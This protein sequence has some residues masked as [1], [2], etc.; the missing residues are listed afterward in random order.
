LDADAWIRRALGTE[1]DPD[2]IPY[3]LSS[4]IPWRR[5]EMLAEKYK[6]GR[7]ILVGDSA[8]TMSP[9]GG[10]GM[11]TGIQE[12]MDLGWKLQGVLAGWAHPDLLD[13]YETERLP[14]AARN[15]SFSTQN[16][17]AWRDTP[18]PAA[19]CDDSEEGQRVRAALGRRLR[20]STRIEWESMGLQIGH[21][22]EGSPV[23]V[24]DGSPPTPD[25]F[26]V[27]V[28]TTRPGSRA[29]HCWLDDGRSTLDLFG[30]GFVLLA[31]PAS[32]PGAI[33]TIR[34]AFQQRGIPLEVVPLQSAEAARLY[35][36]PLVL[37]RPD[38]HVAWRGDQ[39]ADAAHIADTVRGALIGETA[40]H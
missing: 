35:E 38:G 28:P 16:F 5:T 2:R 24:A 17:N 36:R 21:R 15:I 40:V 13:S 22:Y 39:A 20:E 25:D 7:V 8:H 19:V 30:K 23:C 37:V 29:P 32:R 6:Q 27:Y 3:Q 4:V 33:E 11:N 9:T 12:V 14:I 34:G 1:A 26:R 10:M 31:F 18:N